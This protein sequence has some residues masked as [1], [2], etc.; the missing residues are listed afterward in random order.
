VALRLLMGGVSSPDAVRAMLADYRRALAVRR[1]ELST[2]RESLVDRP[3]LAYPA[4][5]ADWGL[6][7][8]DSEDAI[9]AELAERLPAIEGSGASDN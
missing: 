5:V 3:E 4:L 2:V 6:A 9:V 7:Y 8:Y 1:A